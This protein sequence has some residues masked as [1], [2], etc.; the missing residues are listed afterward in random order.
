MASFDFS[1]LNS[2]DLE[3]LV[4]DLLNAKEKDDHSNVEYR[5]FKEGKDKGIDFAY[6]TIGN[7]YEIIGQVKHYYRSGYK[8]LIK[9]IKNEEVLKVKSIA[10]GKYI[11]ATSLDLSF[12]N[13]EEIQSLFIPH[14]ISLQ[15]IY[16][17][18]DLNMLIEAYPIVLDKHF[19]LWYSSTE[20]LR[21]ILNYNIEGRS[22]EFIE[23]ELKKRLRLYVKTPLFEIG[24]NI[25]KENKFLIITGE[26]GSGKT[27]L[28][29]LLLYEYI[30]DDYSLIYIYDDIKEIEKVFGNN[31][32]KQIFYF[33]DFL[34]HNSLEMS[35]SKGSETA[36]LKNLRRISYST[37]KYFILTTRTLIL[38]AASEESENLRRFKKK[39]KENILRLTDYNVGLRDQLVVNHIEESHIKEELKLII[40]NNIFNIIN[41]ENFSPRSVEYI[42]FPEQVNHFSPEEFEEFIIKN[43]NKPDEIWRHAYEQQ[44]GEIDRILLNTLISLGS[45]VKLHE[46]E[47]AF[48]SRLDFEVATN[49]FQRPLNA[50]MKS[51][52]RLLG[53]FIV[54]ELSYEDLDSFDARL[55]TYHNEDGDLYKLINH[56][57]TDFLINFTR[58]NKDEII[59]IIESSYYLTQITT[60]FFPLGIKNKN[61]PMLIENILINKNDFF[62]KQDTQNRDRL[63]LSLLQYI[64]SDLSKSKKIIIDNISKINNWNFLVNDFE[65]TQHFINFLKYLY[66]KEII[67]QIKNKLSPIGKSLILAISDIDVVI[68]LIEDL[69]KTMG[70]SRRNFYKL[71]NNK[72]IVYHFSSLIQEKFDEEIELLIE[73]AD[74]ID[75]PDKKLREFMELRDTLRKY[76]IYT[77]VDFSE[78]N[79]YDWIEI[80]N[81]NY[82]SDQMSKDD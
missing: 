78:Y 33:D 10:P 2:T 60:R 59:R 6:S 42:T 19:K 16:G 46:L 23:E 56:S 58:N 77:D 63:T 15:D 5:T 47:N 14:I 64:Y 69:C 61:F 82:F 31:D 68:E 53:G 39:A 45:R 30:K 52:R 71:I 38:N 9:T 67:D 17:K 35:K 65:I 48:N 37:N 24:K 76:G 22:N 20:I 3:E 21:K 1:T 43:F 34:G 25:L 26:P 66:N 81:E 70:I 50:F 80:A 29:E 32:Q 44:I 51:F 27:T 12:K 57:L 7:K 40:K 11:F 49:N 79:N 73:S 54:P 18:S 4:R 55:D 62:I 72:N 36:L 75:L 41:H 13:K 74:N 8:A 28:A